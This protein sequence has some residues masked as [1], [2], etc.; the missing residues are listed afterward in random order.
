[1]IKTMLTAAMLAVTLMSGA[2]FAQDQSG[3]SMQ[4]D[5]KMADT[6]MKR[7]DHMMKSHK[8]AKH[9]SKKKSHKKSMSMKKSN[10]M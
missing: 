3:Q 8:H 2:A 7:D 10:S 6:M 5:N 9:K 4:S 1:M